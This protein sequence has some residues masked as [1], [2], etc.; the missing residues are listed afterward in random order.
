VPK[1]R[2][3]AIGFLTEDDLE[4]MG[5]TFTRLW[6]VE[7]VSCFAQLLQA[8]DEAEA[9]PARAAGPDQQLQSASADSPSLR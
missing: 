9:D 1:K 6:P 7:D 5:A 4:R 8:I 3:V 2:I